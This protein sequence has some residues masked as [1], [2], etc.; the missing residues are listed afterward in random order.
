[1]MTEE[2]KKAFER[3]Q[4]QRNAFPFCLDDKTEEL[5][6]KNRRHINLEL[7]QYHKWK[8]D[9]QKERNFELA[10][11]IGKELINPHESLRKAFAIAD[12]ILLNGEG[13]IKTSLGVKN[14]HFFKSQLNN[15]S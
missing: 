4:Y 9:A 6:L 7:E 14:R 8:K 3:D 5:Y 11:F 10:G 1:M 2:E 15:C 13:R 12:F